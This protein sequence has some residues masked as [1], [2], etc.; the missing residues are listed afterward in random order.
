MAL[1][2]SPVRAPRAGGPGGTARRGS[3]APTA[4]QARAGRRV[5]RRAFARGS[6]RN[7]SRITAFGAVRS[8]TGPGAQ[9][10]HT[11]AMPF[12]ERDDGVRLHWDLHGQGAEAGGRPRLPAAPGR[13]PGADLGLAKHNTVITYDARGTGESAG[14]RR[15]TWPPTSTT[16]ACWSRSSAR[17]RRCSRTGTRPIARCT[18][19][20]SGPT[21]CRSWCH[22][23]PC[24]STSQAAEG[25]D[26]LVGSSGV[27]QA[28]LGMMRADCRASVKAA[29]RGN[30]ACPPNCASASTR[31]STTAHTRP[32]LDGS[33]RGCATTAPVRCALRDRLVLSA[34]A[35]GEW[36][37][38]D[39]HDRIQDY[40][41]EARAVR[42]G[43]GER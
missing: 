3:R 8:V 28:L 14:S 32:R 24:R 25:S 5:A 41:P 16:C 35:D 7:L 34:Q 37:S 15:T 38:A 13:L 36:F 1:S 21:S 33:R 2:S 31:P 30:R 29:L 17:S 39:L 9:A 26:A 10:C 23:R 4:P 27:L 12:V 6:S 43:G 19:P 18:W 40:L 42:L 22:S 11:S 20:P